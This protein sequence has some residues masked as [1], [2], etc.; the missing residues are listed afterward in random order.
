MAKESQLGKGLGCPVA[1][2]GSLSPAVPFTLGLAGHSQ[3]QPCA[4]GQ[5]AWGERMGKAA[6]M[7]R[8]ESDTVPPL[9]LAVPLHAAVHVPVCLLHGV[10]AQ[11]EA[12]KAKQPS[13]PA[14]APELPWLRGAKIKTK[15]SIFQLHFSPRHRQDKS[16]P[17]KLAFCVTIA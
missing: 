4:A 7:P 16:R 6:E 10:R 5:L 14:L 9:L 2:A 1:T 17:Q 8:L 12:G 13:P 11:E 15:L 3:G